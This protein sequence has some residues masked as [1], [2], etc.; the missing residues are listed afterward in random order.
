M[1]ELAPFANAMTT[2]IV[3]YLLHSTLLLA[4]CWVVIRVTRTDSHILVERLWKVAAVLGILTAALQNTI[5]VDFW[6]APRTI[7]EVAHHRAGSSQPDDTELRLQTTVADPDADA[8]DIAS[9]RSPAAT[10]HPQVTLDVPVSE[11]DDQG[12]IRAS[13]VPEQ[14]E[15]LSKPDWLQS[16]L[17]W[18]SAATALLPLCCIVVGGMLIVVQTMRLRIRFSRE[19]LLETGPARRVLDRFLKSN[20]IRHRIRLLVSSKQTEPV[21]YGLFRWTIVLPENTQGRLAKEELKAL[22]VHEV[23]HLVRG[24]VRWLWIGRVLCTCLAFQPLNFL[25]RRRWQQEAEYLCDDWAV[26]RGIRSLSLARCL[27]QIAEWRF[28]RQPSPVGLAA[29]GSKAT[30]VRRVERLVK[31]QRQAD[32]WATPLRRGLLAL[33]TFIAVISLA[34]F[35]PRVSLPLVRAG[36]R[37]EA[38]AVFVA[39]PIDEATI[40]DWHALEEE[41][42]QL[43]ADLLHADELLRANPLRNGAAA[44]IDDIQ[45]R[46]VSL[47]ARRE[48]ITLLLEKELEQ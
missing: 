34:G 35:A 22:L 2:F 6:I 17:P 36:E 3:T 39:S 32:V 44:H 13:V 23:A 15:T 24:D 37:A 16:A 46:T 4:S 19:R 31:G 9:E 14:A 10:A 42:L 25:A 30:L 26:E 21:T 27:T 48:R 8:K 43:E 12:S 28:G 29:G 47:T 5:G 33:G 38:D 7:G 18:F 11:V 45:L 20:N 1:N 41:L 40:R